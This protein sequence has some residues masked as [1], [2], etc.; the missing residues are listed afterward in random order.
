[1]MMMMVMMLVA[2]HGYIKSCYVDD[3]PPF[4]RNH[5]DFSDLRNTEGTEVRARE[6][7]AQ[8]G[9]ENGSNSPHT[10]R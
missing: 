10:S 5:F 3:I 6:T 4:P 9:K 1:M 8:W 2:L 7:T